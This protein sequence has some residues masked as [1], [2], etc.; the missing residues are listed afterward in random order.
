MVGTAT[1]DL[2]RVTIVAPRSRVDLAIPANVPLAHLLP[3]LLRFAGDDLADVGAAQGGWVLSRLG[4]QQLDSSRTPGQLNIRDGEVLYFTTRGDA[5]PELV[6]DDVADAVAT[7]TLERGGRWTL[8][9]TRRASLAMGSSALVGGAAAVLFVGPPQW[10]GGLVGLLMG[11]ALVATSAILSRAMRAERAGVLFALVAICY[12]AV[13]GL[14]ILGGDKPVGKL[15]APNVLLAAVAVVVYAAILTV[16]TSGS[17]PL[18]LGA[19][20]GGA[21]IGLGAAACTMLHTTPAGA[22]A[23]IAAVGLGLIPFLAMFATRAARVPVPAVPTGPEDLKAD[24]ETIDGPALLTQ[25]NRADAI[26]TAILGASAVI[27]FGVELI[28]ALDGSLPALLF[29]VLLGLI[30]LVRARPYRGRAQRVPMIAAGW[31]GLGFA[32]L[33]FFL[34]TDT[35][36]RLTI[37]LPGLFVAAIAALVYGLGVAGKKIAPIWGRTLDIIEIILVV[38]AI[39]MAVWVSGLYAWVRSIKG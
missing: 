35:L 38:A 27:F 9:T 33:G 6:F 1:G 4:G 10:V 15:G 19:T 30:L 8:S 34:T 7:A 28:L 16:V 22:A 37:V 23:V 5:A 13:G 24:E 26:M 11:L 29:C 32:A 20:A 2:S 14:L 39:P 3:T 25:S 31:A 12:A 18:L 17:T 21:V 36:M